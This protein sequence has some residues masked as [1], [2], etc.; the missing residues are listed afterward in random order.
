MDGADAGPASEY[1]SVQW[2]GVHVSLPGPLLIKFDQHKY[3][4]HMQMDTSNAPNQV[5]SHRLGDY[6]TVFYDIL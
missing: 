5:A 4:A 6:G 3:T 2:P 1:S